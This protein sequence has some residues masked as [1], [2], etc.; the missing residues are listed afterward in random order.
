MRLF[1]L[2]LRRDIRSAEPTSNQRTHIAHPKR[3]GAMYILQRAIKESFGQAFS[4][5]AEPTGNQRTHIARPK[6]SGALYILQ[7]AI[8][9]SFR[10][11]FSKGGG[12]SGRRP[13]AH[14]AECEIPSIVRKTQERVNFFA[15]QRKRENPRRGFSFKCE[16]SIFNTSSTAV[17]VP[18]SRCGSVTLRL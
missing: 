1:R 16:N 2:L 12:F 18:L 3:S 9:E 7:R 5:S 8:K 15:K 11:P 14:S 4:K 6:K 10:P 13:E 17:A